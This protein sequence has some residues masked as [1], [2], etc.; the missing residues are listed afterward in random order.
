MTGAFR[1]DCVMVE[2]MRMYSTYFVRTRGGT[3][4]VPGPPVQIG[5]LV[6]GVRRVRD[7][8]H[9]ELEPVLLQVVRVYSDC[10]IDVRVAP[11]GLMPTS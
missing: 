11:H 10:S 5:E 2:G 7:V 3:S 9:P 8:P 6:Y 1:D 4:V